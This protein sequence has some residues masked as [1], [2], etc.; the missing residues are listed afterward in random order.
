MNY[1]EKESKIQKKAKLQ[2]K[3]SFFLSN[4]N[5]IHQKLRENEMKL[6]LIIEQQR[7]LDKKLTQIRDK[8]TE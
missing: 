6:L 8:I 3:R 2:I 1:F 7:I 4:F 5:N